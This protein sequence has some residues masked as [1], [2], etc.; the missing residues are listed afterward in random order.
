MNLRSWHPC[1]L[2]LGTLALLAAAGLLFPAVASA[3]LSSPSVSAETITSVEEDWELVVGEPDTTTNGPQVTCTISPFG[4]LS[5]LHCTYELNH[6]S[7]PS[8]EAGGMQLVLW[9]GEDSLAVKR[10]D[11]NAQLQHDNET[12]RWTQR[13]SLSG[14]TATFEVSNGS[15]TTWGAFGAAGKLKASHT[16]GLTS[17][18]GYS[19]DLSARHS[20]VGFA[21]NRVVSLILKEV[22]WYA[23]GVLVH[24]DT[25]ARVVHQR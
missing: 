1:G 13:M 6:K 22:R 16:T 21:S 23:S 20:G 8:F 4:D 7:V 19:P 11:N 14:T 24:R 3:Q 12:I 15:S 18:A 9:S 17:L 5:G 25:N 2:A 10:F